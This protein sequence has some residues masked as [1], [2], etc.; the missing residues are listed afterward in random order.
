MPKTPNESIMKWQDGDTV[1]VVLRGKDYHVV[2]VLMSGTKKTRQQVKEEAEAHG[3]PKRR[4][5]YLLRRLR[6]F[7]CVIM[8]PNFMDMRTRLVRFKDDIEVKM[9]EANNTATIKWNK[10]DNEATKK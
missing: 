7:G 4:S 8:E 6:D 10:R 3:V 2:K 9:N 5:N 1:T